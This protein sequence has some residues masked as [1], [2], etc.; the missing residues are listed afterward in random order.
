MI[1]LLAALAAAAPLVEVESE[2]VR[3]LITNVAVLGPDGRLTGIHDV[4]LAEGKVAEL[5]PV[6]RGWDVP[7]ER[8]V[9]GSGATLMPGLVDLHVH[10]SST[11]AVPGKLRIPKPADTLDQLLYW[12]VT[13]VL[14]L[15]ESRERMDT[16]SAR[17]AQ[18][19]QAGP[20]L[21]ASGRPFAAPGG[22]PR[23][24]V[25]AMYPGFL[26]RLATKGTTHEVATSGDVDGALAAEGASGFTK[27]VLDALPGESPTLGDEAAQRLRL[28]ATAL[29]DRLIAHVGQPADVQRALELPVDALAHLPWAGA[30]TD[31][32]VAALVDQR[33]PV[34][35]TLAVYEANG[36]LH[37]QR[38]LDGQ[39][40]RES[41]TRPQ[42]R[43]LDR[44][45]AGK[46]PVKGELE[47]WMGALLGEQDTRQSNARRLYDAGATLL[48]G[49]DSP[50][51]GLAAG[52]GTHRELEALVRAGVPI[53]YVL[54]AVTWE[55]ARF[56]DP[57]GEF[58][59]VLPGWQADLL[60]VDG[61]PTEDLS[62]LQDIR[63]LW[64]DGLRV[65]RT[66]RD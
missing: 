55:N 57:D 36:L 56:L 41:L 29:G 51:T 12:G 8:T 22:H 64:V 27:V 18:G 34:T 16:Y 48:V 28:G 15:S 59:A 52:A 2:P 7:V 11:Y 21:Y 37:A 5:L 49:S 9:D 61:D 26:V 30:L 47:P 3:T 54:S 58:G 32:Q 6:G 31:A 66:A 4:V 13:T 42:Q 62:A 14:D 23:S 60:L 39:L 17:I 20:A 19:K 44:V 40:E 33:I 38:P 46:A 65:T 53:E 35:P 25:L 10:L 24:T 43:D 63:E 45:I 1:L 50:I